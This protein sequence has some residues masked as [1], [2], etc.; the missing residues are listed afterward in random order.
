MRSKCLIFKHM[1]CILLSSFI[2]HLFNWIDCNEGFFLLI[3]YWNI[4]FPRFFM[5]L[6]NNFLDNLSQC[7]TIDLK[8]LSLDYTLF[9]GL[10]SF[11]FRPLSGLQGGDHARLRVVIKKRTVWERT[12]TKLA[13]SRESKQNLWW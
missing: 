2:Y 5:I 13:H 10:W 8:E 3:F 9:S 7:F 11:Q 12:S 4:R 6:R 1:I